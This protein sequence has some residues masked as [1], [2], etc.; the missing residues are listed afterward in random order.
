MRKLLAVLI[1]L[2]L[3]L[4]SGCGVKAEKIKNPQKFADKMSYFRADDGLCYGVVAIKKM[5]WF[6]FY[7]E[8]IGLTCI[9][10]KILEEKGLLKE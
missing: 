8:G 9:D 2:S 1:I 6:N 4:L 3:V 7:Q 10:C 5:T